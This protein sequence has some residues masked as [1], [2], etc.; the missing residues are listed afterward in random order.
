[1]TLKRNRHALDSTALEQSIL[2]DV[3]QINPSTSIFGRDLAMPVRDLL[4]DINCFALTFAQ[5]CPQFCSLFA[6]VLTAPMGSSSF[7]CFFRVFS[8]C[9]FFR[10]H[11]C[12]L[13]ARS[14]SFWP[15]ATSPRST[16][17]TP[18]RANQ[19]PA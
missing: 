4:S 11:C 7:L 13:F 3:S 5:F 2:N 6:Q 8:P 10:E 1:M 9:V 19:P 15:Q 12:S 17:H 18:R 16:R 14:F